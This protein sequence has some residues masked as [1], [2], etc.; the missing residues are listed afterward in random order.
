MYRDDSDLRVSFTC[1]NKFN[2]E[3]SSDGF[4]IYLF[5]KIIEGN[6]YTTLYLKVEFNNAKTGKTV[7][8][9]WPGE[10]EYGEKLGY[11]LNPFGK[12]GNNYKFKALK[13]CP[14]DYEVAETSSGLT[15]ITKVDINKLLNDLYIPICVK[16][17]FETREF[18]WFIKCDYRYN[19]CPN[20][21]GNIR[22]VQT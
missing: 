15:G 5:D 16:Y 7:P 18:V 21:D 22:L 10:T 14:K 13:M 8:F 6:G 19:I 11:C 2:T 12:N 1:S 17:N 4:Y 20:N 3:S 9:L